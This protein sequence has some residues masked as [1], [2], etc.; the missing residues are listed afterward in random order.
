MHVCIYIWDDHHHQCSIN[1]IMINPLLGVDPT[2]RTRARAH[3]ILSLSSS[4]WDP[5]QQVVVNAVS[6]P[7]NLWQLRF[8][9]R[10]GS[11]VVTVGQHTHRDR[12][13]WTKTEL[14]LSLS[15]PSIHGLY[16]LYYYN[17]LCKW[18]SRSD[19]H[20]DTDISDRAIASSGPS[21]SFLGRLWLDFSRIAVFPM[22]CF[23]EDQH[24]GM[25]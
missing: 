7:S 9:F 8:F 6:W 3:V 11:T 21:D 14:S 24:F 2:T 18:N 17:N 10:V 1:D 22:T 23:T 20:A 19:G 5:Q 16:L 25:P 13:L 12:T 15:F 4:T